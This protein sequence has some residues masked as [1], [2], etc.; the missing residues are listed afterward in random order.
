[1]APVV[2]STF[3][4]SLRSLPGFDE[5]VAFLFD[6]VVSEGS[7]PNFGLGSGDL[8][9]LVVLSPS[10][11]VPVVRW[12]R[13]RITVHPKEGWRPNTVYRVELL[14]GV[15]DLSRN[16]TKRPV[17]VTFS[18]GET[19]P[20][21]SLVGRVVDWPTQR[22]APLGLV[23]AVLQPDSL[24][25]RTT[26]DSTGRFRFGPLPRGEY[27]VYGV[28]EEGAKN[29]RR[30]SREK[31]DSVR[32]AVGRDSVGEVWAFK[33]DTAAAKIQTATRSD[34]VTALVAFNQ[35][36]DPYQ[37]FVADSVELM[38]LPGLDPDPGRGLV[39]ARPSP[40][41]WRGPGP[42][43]SPRP[44]R[45]PSPRPRVT[46]P[47]S[48]PT[49]PRPAPIPPRPSGTRAR[50][51]S[52]GCRGPSP[53][54]GGPAWSGTPWT[55]RLLKTKPPLF[56]KLVVRSD[57]LL[58]EGSRYIILIRGIRSVSGVTGEARGALDVPVK[59]PTAA[60]SARADSAK[61]GRD[62]VPPPPRDTMPARRDT[63]PPAASGVPPPP[64]SDPR[65]T[66]PSVDRLLRDPD[67]AGADDAG[68]AE[69][70]RGRGA[71]G[72][73]GCPPRRHRT[74]RVGGGGP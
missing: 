15:A 10:N 19:L 37:T 38:Q 16:L 52:S 8:E 63:V 22:P 47:R 1:M 30:D 41:A 27:L 21:D 55:W 44:G 31:F 45:T 54:S 34:S 4:D 50:P 26:A 3:P 13:N 43:A 62:S 48:R 51:G 12:K 61:A 18:T 49:R 39:D 35:F 2:R 72:A 17:V 67:I 32:V 29:S 5:D 36:L 60:D 66:L 74:R 7:Q 46:A 64:M 14:P 24:V 71:R 23:E 73:G 9:R 53:P 40:T 28:V 59:K 65:R 6:E 58:R 42:T 69:R 70:R 11:E 56:D 20:T 57:S 33:H 25:Y 68:P